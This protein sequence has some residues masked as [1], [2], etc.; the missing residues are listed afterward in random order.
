[1]RCHSFPVSNVIPSSDHGK[2]DLSDLSKQAM[3]GDVVMQG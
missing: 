3:A 2:L 1:M